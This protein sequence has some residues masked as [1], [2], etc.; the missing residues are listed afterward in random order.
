MLAMPVSLHT[1][2][3]VLAKSMSVDATKKKYSCR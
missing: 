1:Q 2:G 3:V